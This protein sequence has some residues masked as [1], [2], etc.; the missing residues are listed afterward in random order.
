M[1]AVL[2]QV[3]FVRRSHK[4]PHPADDMD[5]LALS[6]FS[7]KRHEVMDEEGYHSGTTAVVCIL[8]GDELTVANAGDS[9]CVVSSKGLFYL[10]ICTSVQCIQLCK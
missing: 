4:R 7:V 10:H 9:R 1:H 8:K 3:P 6:K 5:D 2:I